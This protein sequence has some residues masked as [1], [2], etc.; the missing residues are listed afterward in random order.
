MRLS[1]KDLDVGSPCGC[2]LARHQNLH[3]PIH[4]ASSGLEAKYSAIY[5][6]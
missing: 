1:V 2:P 4:Q 5:D 6:L 3:I